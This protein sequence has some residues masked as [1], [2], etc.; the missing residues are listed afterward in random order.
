MMRGKLRCGL[1]SGGSC[2]GE[3]GRGAGTRSTATPGWAMTNVTS[4]VLEHDREVRRAFRSVR[5]DRPARER[6]G[7]LMI[8][9]ISQR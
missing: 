7:V 4:G 5:S 1:K 2:L 9:T 6:R 8:D 3:R